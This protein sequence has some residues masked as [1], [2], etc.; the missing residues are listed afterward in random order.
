MKNEVSKAQ[1]LFEK[2][3]KNVND[4]SKCDPNAL[5]ELLKISQDEAKK[6]VQS[7]G[8]IVKLVSEFS[9]DRAQ[10]NTL[11]AQTRVKIEDLLDYLLP[12]EMADKLRA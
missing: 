8:S 2:G 3:V 6:A 7:A 4:L 12:K 1:I 5:S 10:L 9:G 11:A